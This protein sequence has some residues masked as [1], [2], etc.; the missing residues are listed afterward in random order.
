MRLIITAVTL[1]EAR[2]RRR[3]LQLQR[4]K[5]AMWP[6][7]ACADLGGCHAPPNKSA[8]TP[9]AAFHRG[10]VDDAAAMNAKNRA[11]LFE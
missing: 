1:F 11:R 10:H 9:V 8:T 4:A 7:V 2:D 3:E 5:W 6:R